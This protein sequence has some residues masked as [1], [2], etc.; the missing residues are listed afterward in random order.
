M[1]ENLMGPVA[2]LAAVLLIG[3]VAVSVIR[4]RM[5]ETPANDYDLLSE[6]QAAY[7]AGDIDEEEYRRVRDSLIKGKGGALAGGG[8]AAKVDRPPPLPGQPA[9]G[10]RKSEEPPTDLPVV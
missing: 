1:L 10:P 3:A 9:E 7:D 8:V 2:L 5:V 4:R 6:F